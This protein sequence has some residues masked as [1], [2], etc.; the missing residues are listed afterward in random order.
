MEPEGLKKET[1]E[2]VMVLLYYGEV[3]LHY[4]SGSELALAYLFH[5]HEEA[6]AGYRYCAEL[7]GELRSL[8]E[9][10]QEAAHKRLVKKQLVKLGGWLVQY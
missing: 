6:V 7:V 8:P 2:Y 5:E 4:A 1:C 10:Q 3:V 9:D